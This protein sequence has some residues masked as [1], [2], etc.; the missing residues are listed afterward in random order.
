[1]LESPFSRSLGRKTSCKNANEQLIVTVKDAK[2]RSYYIPP[3]LSWERFSFFLYCHHFVSLNPKLTM[4]VVIDRSI[5]II[6]MMV[7]FLC[8]LYKHALPQINFTAPNTPPHKPQPLR[9]RAESK[10]II[11]GTPFI[12]TERDICPVILLF[13]CATPIST[14]VVR[15]QQTQQTERFVQNSMTVTILPLLGW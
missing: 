4:F 10:S 1:M 15:Q 2:S 14:A 12:F 8:L 7:I 3:V 5:N 6:L 9:C 11:V 13:Y